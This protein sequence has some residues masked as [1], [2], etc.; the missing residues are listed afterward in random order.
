MAGS[1]WFKVE[2][3]LR[4]KRAMRGGASGGGYGGEGRGGS[5]LFESLDATGTSCRKNELGKRLH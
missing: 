4:D 1:L 5:G 3:L 2:S